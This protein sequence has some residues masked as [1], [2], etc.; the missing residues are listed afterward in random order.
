[1]PLNDFNDQKEIDVFLDG[2]KSQLIIQE[3]F[4]IEKL[5]D[6]S[7][8]G[9]KKIIKGHPNQSYGF[10]ISEELQGYI[11]LQNKT[12]PYCIIGRSFHFR[13]VLE[14]LFVNP[15]FILVNISLYDIKIYRGDFQYI[16][17]T[18]QYEF[19]QIPKN[20]ND[21]Q[22]HL[23]APQY[24]G[25][26]PYKTI[27][28]MKTV[29]QRIKDMILY[30]SIPVIV[31]GI[32]VMKSQ[33]LRF[34]DES[35]GMIT[36]FN[37]DFFEKDTREITERCKLFRSAITDYYSN[38]LKERL[39]RMTKSKLI[40]S[41]FGEIIKATFEGKVTHL[42]FPPNLKIWGTI[43]KLTGEFTIHKKMSKNSVDILSELAEE[44]IKQGGGMKILLPHFFPQNVNVLAILKGRL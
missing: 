22:I 2:M 17:I 27:L 40:I 41:D 28:A 11:I 15:E 44:V 18:Q 19:D 6:K 1:M 9:I 26:V 10:F 35:P 32:D 31:T 13:P 43:D 12:E 20:L 37:E 42:V 33:F 39:K 14:E 34:F 38:Q 7:C 8:Q 36:H 30:E 5:L 16:E 23:F 4:S 21:S 29:S 24:L 25:S 3:K